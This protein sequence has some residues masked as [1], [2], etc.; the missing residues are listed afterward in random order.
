MAFTLIQA[1]T[2]LYTMNADGGVAASGSTPTP[3]T[4]PTGVTLVGNRIPRFVRYNNFL[5]LVN[6]PS[7]P[8]TVGFDGVTRPLTPAAPAT[9][10][11]LSGSSG[12]TLSG[13]FMV[14][15]TFVILD[16]NG[17]IIAESDYSPVSQA[18]TISNQFLLASNLSTSSEQIS[19]RQ[20]YRTTDNGS[21][22]FPW[23]VL[24][25]NT[26]TAIADDMTD[27][28]IGLVASEPRGTA[29]DLTLITE[30]NGRLWGVSRTD[31]DHI[32]YTEAGEIFAWNLENT[33]PIP[34][35]GTDRFGIVALMPRRDALGV[36]R[37]TNIVQVTGNLT[38][39]IRQIN[40]SENC[41]VESQESVVT[42]RDTVFF[43]WRDGVYTWDANGISCISDLGGVRSW[44]NTDSYF[45]RAMFSRAFAI[46]DPFNLVY[47]LYLASAG[48]TVI[49]HWVEY[50]LG[51]GKWYGPHL[52]SAFNPS[53]ALNVRGRNNQPYNMVGSLQGYVSQN[54]FGTYND[55]SFAP[56]S[57]DV[58]T[59]RH[60]GGNPDRET[61]FGELSVLGEKQASGTALIT[62]IVGGV[63]ETIPSPPLTWDLGKS[64]VRLGRLGVGKHVQL[65]ITNNNLNENVVLYGYTLPF[66]D[67]GRR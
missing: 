30:W 17:N 37:R 44:F 8:I 13:T 1:G 40:L 34:H 49:D 9:P 24:N 63:A 43:L 5:V 41:G 16:S 65:E 48:S 55:W 39:N 58:I 27:A 26:A 35:L 42:Y 52:T 47:Q 60:D 29:P 64:R 61:Y 57:L 54:V 45:N 19:A 38:D 62:P 31:I 66:N 10:A 21:T 46:I 7:K 56:I 14:K 3:L 2:N 50:H 59:K 51:S 22:Y 11:T 67:V 12:G 33:L 18:V 15:Y 23:I 36:A 25:G 20:L 28:Q 53:C 32:V 6:T 4:L